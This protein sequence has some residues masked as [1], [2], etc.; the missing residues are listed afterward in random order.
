MKRLTVLTVL[1]IVAISTTGCGARRFRLWN[2][3]GDPCNVCDTC[4]GAT[5]MDGAYG[6]Y[7]PET[8]GVYPG[9]AEVITPAP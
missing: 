7:L 5:A 4:G 9:P 6:T 3:W 1:L 8:T 2:Q